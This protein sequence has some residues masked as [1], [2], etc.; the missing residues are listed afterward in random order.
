MNNS[1]NVQSQ[2]F[3]KAE[4]GVQSQIPAKSQE[5]IGG[6]IET[7]ASLVQIFAAA[8]A[9]IAATIAARAQLAALVTS[10]RAAI[11]AAE[12]TYR[13]LRQWAEVKFGR[14]SPILAAF[15]F[16]QTQP[17]AKSSATKAKAAALAKQTRVLHG[18]DKGKRQR[19]ALTVSGSPG[20]VLYGADGKPIPGLL[21][22]P[23]APVTQGN[24]GSTPSG[25]GK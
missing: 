18:T 13:D 10:Q 2:K 14:G 9:A 4:A 24:A 1:N 22:G 8:Q 7:Q 3:S 21:P 15:G 11:Q 19:Q 12:Q 5:T 17:K 16:K 23:V 20:L 25:S 6:K